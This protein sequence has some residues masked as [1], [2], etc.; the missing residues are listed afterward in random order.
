MHGPLLAAVL[1][2]ILCYHEVDPPADTH[3]TVPRLSATGDSQSESLRYTVT[4]ENFTAQLDY[5]QR[6][7]YTVIP[8]ARLVG[9]LEGR[10]SSLPPRAVVITV[11]DGWQCAYT[12][13]AP[14]LR[15]RG[16][17]FTLFVYPGIVGRGAHAVTWEEVEE[18]ARSGVDIE[19]HTLSHPFLTKLDTPS[20]ERELAQSR[21]EIARHTGKAPRFLSYPYGDYNPQVMQCAASVGYDAAVTTA[22][23]PITLE[24]PPLE[25]KRFLLHH[26]TTLEEFKTFLP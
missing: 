19:S 14:E 17:P 25:L 22:R 16:L 7:G 1:A 3:L 12:R 11:D 5:L 4:P 15:K 18:L 21:E 24:T 6:G 23:G 20:L 26:D 2:T 13:I 10:E 9:Y 8:L